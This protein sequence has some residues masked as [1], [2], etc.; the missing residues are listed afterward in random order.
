MIGTNEREYNKKA[1]I[2]NDST[3]LLARIV[4][5]SFMPRLQKI[6]RIGI[7][8]LFVSLKCRHTCLCRLLIVWQN[9]KQRGSQ[10]QPPK[11]LR[12]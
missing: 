4:W 8:V 9:E 2:K 7:R 6:G 1:E 3:V 5:F 11:L 10:F 12:L